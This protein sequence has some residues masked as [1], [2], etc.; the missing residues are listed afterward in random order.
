[1]IMAVRMVMIRITTMSSMSVKPW[2]RTAAEGRDV[3][4]SPVAHVGRITFA[5]VRAVGTL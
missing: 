4:G 5:T 3:T 2:K 1:M